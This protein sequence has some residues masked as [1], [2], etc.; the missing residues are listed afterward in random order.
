MKQYFEFVKRN[1]VQND[2]YFLF[3]SKYRRFK[4]FKEEFIPLYYFSQ[5]KYCKTDMKM[6]III[7]NQ[8]YDALIQEKDGTI[9]KFE[10]TLYE[11][12][13]FENYDAKLLE[14]R[15]YGSLRFKDNVNFEDR[16]ND[17]FHQIMKNIIK[18]SKTD[19]TDVNIIICAN[20]FYYF[21]VFNK[22]SK[23]FVDR[24]IKEIRKIKFTAKSVYLMVYNKDPISKITKNIYLVMYGQSNCT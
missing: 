8:P 1:I 12:G 15:G 4:Q 24:L 9:N 3:N 19:Y 22:S 21:E 16:E 13:K 2:L 5:S 18:K 6:Q 14:E 20:T 17:Y 10:F 7:G 11:D 23:P